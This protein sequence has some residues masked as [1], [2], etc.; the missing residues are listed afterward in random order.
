MKLFRVRVA[1][2]NYDD[3]QHI[4]VLFSQNFI[5]LFLGWFNDETD[6]RVRDKEKG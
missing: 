4:N 1:Y 6:L 3:F 2:D 5:S